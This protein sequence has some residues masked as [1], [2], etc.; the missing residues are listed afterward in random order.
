MSFPDVLTLQYRHKQLFKKHYVSWETTSITPVTVESLLQM[1][2]CRYVARIRNMNMPEVD[3]EEQRCRYPILFVDIDTSAE[4]QSDNTSFGSVYELFRPDEYPINALKSSLPAKF[5]KKEW[6][7]SENLEKTNIYSDTEMD[8]IV[9]YDI[10]SIDVPSWFGMSCVP[11]IFTLDKELAMNYAII[12]SC[13]R[14]GIDVSNDITDFH[15]KVNY[16]ERIEKDLESYLF[17]HAPNKGSAKSA[18]VLDVD[19]IGAIKRYVAWC[20]AKFEKRTT[21]SLAMFRN[22][23][24][25]VRTCIAQVESG[26]IQARKR[27]LLMLTQDPDHA[28]LKGIGTSV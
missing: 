2:L 6:N 10:S 7:H 8:V 11:Q 16:N 17:T 24:D 3:A 26:L 22:D 25:E 19:G 27:R 9:G 12:R 23:T 21:L 14:E 20:N 5:E 1:T 15:K 28:E 4:E 18:L 13:E